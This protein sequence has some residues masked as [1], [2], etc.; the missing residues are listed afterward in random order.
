M[1][2]PSEHKINVRV[3]TREGVNAAHA[4]AK[5][6]DLLVELTEHIKESFQEAV[7]LG[8]EQDEPVAATAKR[9]GTS[10]RRGSKSK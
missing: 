3:Q 10:S 5:G 4:F 7:E 9:K 1:P 2:H 6:L 8:P